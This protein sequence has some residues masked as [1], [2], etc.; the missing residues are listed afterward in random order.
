MKLSIIAGALGLLISLTSFTSRASG[1]ALQVLGVKAG[2][3][4]GRGTL[5]SQTPG[6][7][8]LG[9]ISRRTLGNG[10]ITASTR[11]YVLSPSDLRGQIISRLVLGEVLTQLLQM[12]IAEATAQLKVLNTDAVNFKLIDM[13]TKALAGSGFCAGGKCTFTARVSSG[14]ELNE[15][16]TPTADGFLISGSQNFYGLKSVY[17]AE[18]NPPPAQ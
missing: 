14:L 2:V 16:W 3:Y 7:P 8:N 6:I 18:M 5:T 13:K 9:F 10:M 15:T 1:Q 4:Q 11:A 17:T 12:P